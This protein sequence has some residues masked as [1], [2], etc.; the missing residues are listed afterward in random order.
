MTCSQCGKPE[1]HIWP[2]CNQAEKLTEI[3]CEHWMSLSRCSS[4]DALWVGVPYEPYASFTYF[5]IWEKT[6][7]QWQQAM[8]QLKGN[9]LFAWH[10]QQLKAH[11]HTLTNDDREA[12]KH[13]QDRSGGRAP[14]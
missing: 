8:A 4:C 12:I 5:V 11:E 1:R 2:P 13:H 9:A 10:T 7:E 6:E 3:A 14:Y